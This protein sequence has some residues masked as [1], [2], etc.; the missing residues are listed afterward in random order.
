MNLI[1]ALQLAKQPAAQD[2]PELGVVLACGFTPL[3]LQ[4]YLHA[5]LRQKNP[6]HRIRIDTGIFGDLAGNLQRTRPANL[7]A[8]VAVIEWSDID[9]RLGFRNLGTWRVGDM[10]DILQSSERQLARIRQSITDVAHTVPCI[11]TLPTLPLPP[12]FPQRTGQSGPQEM[13]LR[14]MVEEFGV[15]LAGL[16]RVRLLSPQALDEISP[17]HTRYEIRTD[18]M[19]GF[20]YTLI[21][22]EKMATLLAELI[23][24]R[25]AMKGLITDLDDTLWSGILGEVGMEGICWD[26]N[27]HALLH[28]LYQQFLA[29]LASSG[30]LLA[31]ASRNDPALANLALERQDLLLSKKWI[32]P[33]ECHWSLKSESVARI[34]KAWNISADSVVFVDDSPMEIA[35]VQSEFPQLD[36]RV[37]PKDDPGGVLQLLRALRDCFGKSH[38]S[39][40][41]TLR[42]G[43]LRSAGAL[44]ATGMQGGG[45]Q[46]DFLRD[47]MAVVV[48]EMTQAEDERAFEL[49]NKTNQF[50]LNGRRL[51][52]AEWSRYLGEKN[53]FLLCAQYEDKFGRLGKIAAILGRLQDRQVHIDS[54]V[55]S[56][57]AFSRR[58]EHQYLKYLFE[59]FNVDEVSFDYQFT[60]RNGPMQEF[61]VQMTATPLTA[62]VRLRKADCAAR[63]PPLFHQ[64]RESNHA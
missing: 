63:L 40:E 23:Q 30:V 48:F 22:A 25:P 2:A 41:D 39:E 11:C 53:T 19:S 20:P 13:R 10:A 37:F 5:T 1:E 12:L 27:S 43:S 18:M 17:R 15:A 38:I 64:V 26:L 49:I 35:Q 62:P 59:K 6:Q 4:T 52:E 21:H 51:G 55:M 54:W 58:I 33:V 47:A 34:L 42:L 24:N 45:S 56:C 9:P 29:S 16:T 28:G 50:N 57:R 7:Q 60:E 31:V 36:C 14:C 61:L 3:H 44:Q 8:V 46:D 32:Y